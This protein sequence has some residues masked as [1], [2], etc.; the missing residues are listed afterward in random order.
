VAA[1]ADTAHT[2]P[3]AAAKFSTKRDANILP[4]DRDNESP[5]LLLDACA[6]IV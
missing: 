3:K 2:K 6:A 4:P 1:K 5:S